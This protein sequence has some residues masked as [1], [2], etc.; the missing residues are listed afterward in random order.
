MLEF[1]CRFLFVVFL[2]VVLRLVMILM[3]ELWLVMFLVVVILLIVIGLRVCRIVRNRR[4]ITREPIVA[5]VVVLRG[6]VV[7]VFRFV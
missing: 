1:R 7:A 6:I 2:L 3:V 5:L 4:R